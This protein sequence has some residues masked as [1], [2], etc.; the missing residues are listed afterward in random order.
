MRD[1]L[2]VYSE[3]ALPLG[4]EEDEVT[5]KNDCQSEAE[6]RLIKITRTIKPLF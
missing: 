2:T 4:K 6:L 5:S 1:Q 3:V